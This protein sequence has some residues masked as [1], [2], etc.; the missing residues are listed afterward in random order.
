M[1]SYFFF[2]N[3]FN[4]KKIRQKTAITNPTA[5]PI[6][7]Q[8]NISVTLFLSSAFPVI[9]GQHALSQHAE[10]HLKKNFKY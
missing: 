3:C 7:K 2:M 8:N 6:F 9:M 4:L 10:K 5:I 1:T